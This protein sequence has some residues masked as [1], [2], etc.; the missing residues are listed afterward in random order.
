MIAH[1]HITHHTLHRHAPT[2]IAQNPSLG[3]KEHV[4]GSWLG[5]LGWECLSPNIAWLDNAS[6]MTRPEEDYDS[7]QAQYRG[8]GALFTCLADHR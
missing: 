4:F 2:P 5:M 8:G 1:I 7:V 3:S 6:V